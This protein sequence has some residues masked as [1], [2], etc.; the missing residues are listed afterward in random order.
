MLN[1][2]RAHLRGTPFH[3]ESPRENNG[4]GSHSTN[5]T[6]GTE[7]TKRGIVRVQTPVG[8]GNEKVERKFTAKKIQPSPGTLLQKNCV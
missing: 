1:E 6:K 4:K 8:K 5:G 2:L 3:K 7:K